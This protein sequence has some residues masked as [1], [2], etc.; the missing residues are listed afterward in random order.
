MYTPQLTKPKAGNKY[1]NTPFYLGIN[2]GKANPK[3]MDK[4]LTALPNCVSYVIGRFNEIIGKGTIEYFKLAYYP[5]AIINVAKRSGLTVTTEPTLGGMMVWTGGTTGEGHVAIC[6]EIFRN[7]SGIITSVTSSDSEYYGAA[8][9]TFKRAINK[10]NWDKGC[11]WMMSAAKAGKPYIYQGCIN[12]PAV[13][14]DEPVTYEEFCKFMDRYLADLAKKPATPGR[15]K[16]AVDY[17]KEKGYITGD[18]K[19]NTM[20]KSW[21]TRE[22]FCTVIYN[23]LMDQANDN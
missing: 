4:G 11:S 22:Q 5:Y 2:P 10:G 20:P 19:G 1:Y 7:K 15:P 6:E 12:N 16:E 18:S 14:E 23:M 13:K 3:T 17:M 9:K 21:M 8:F